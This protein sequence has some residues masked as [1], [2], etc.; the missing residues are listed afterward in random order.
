LGLGWRRKLFISGI[1]ALT[2]FTR[3][4]SDKKTPL[5]LLSLSLMKVIKRGVPTGTRPFWR[6]VLLLVAILPAVV[7]AQK[8][9]TLADS[10]PD[11]ETETGQSPFVSNT[12]IEQPSTDEGLVRKSLL[13][14]YVGR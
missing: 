12:T 6:L 10:S 13:L 1:S 9:L 7:C 2:F 8:N 4:P 14:L 3:G 11:R 5:F